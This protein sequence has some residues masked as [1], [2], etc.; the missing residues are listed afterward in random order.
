M[1]RH[2]ARAVGVDHLVVQ[3]ADPTPPVGH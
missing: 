2:L 3:Y 1:L